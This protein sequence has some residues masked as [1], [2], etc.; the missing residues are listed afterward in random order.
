MQTKSELIAKAR[1]KESFENVIAWEQRI[2]EQAFNGAQFAAASKANM[3]LASLADY[4]QDKISKVE[5]GRPGEFAAAANIEELL[6]AAKDQ[7]DGP[8]FEAY[9]LMLTALQEGRGEEPPVID[10]TPDDYEEVPPDDEFE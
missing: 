9:Q 1:E 7:L 5:H 10:V 6:I 3:N 8:H 2:R 4:H